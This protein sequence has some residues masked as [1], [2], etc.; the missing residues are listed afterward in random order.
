MVELE[1]WTVQGEYF[2]AT[3]ETAFMTCHR[4]HHANI[5]LFFF[6]LDKLNVLESEGEVEL[7]FH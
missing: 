2:F 5:F 3:D 1:H 7:R 6:R 4:E